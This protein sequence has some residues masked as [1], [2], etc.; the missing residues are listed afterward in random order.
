MTERPTTKT[1]ET[2]LF[3]SINHES[4]HSFI[5]DKSNLYPLEARHGTRAT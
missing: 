2:F 1:W 3:V 4:W 5:T